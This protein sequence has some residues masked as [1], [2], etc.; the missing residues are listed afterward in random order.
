MR[1]WKKKEMSMK[2]RVDRHNQQMQEW[3]H[4]SAHQKWMVDDHDRIL[5]TCCDETWL[6]TLQ[7]P[8]QWQ[9]PHQDNCRWC[10]GSRDDYQIGNCGSC[11]TLLDGIVGYNFTVI[12]TPEG[13]DWPY[14]A[15]SFRV[16][17]FECAA[18]ESPGLK[19]RLEEDTKDLVKEVK[20]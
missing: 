8:K 11:R 3:T 18:K 2:E 1:R 5:H 6:L 10:K 17:C 14:H 20:E 19:K 15:T 13:K 16:L 12:V 4:K 9:L 7:G